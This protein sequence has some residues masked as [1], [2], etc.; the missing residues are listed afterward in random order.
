MSEN[1]VTAV[2]PNYETF[3]PK[4]AVVQLSVSG[5][6]LTTTWVPFSFFMNTRAIKSLAFGLGVLK[7]Q[8]I[9]EPVEFVIQARN[10]NG[11]NRKSGRDGFFVS[12]VT[13]TK[14]EVPCEITD[15]ENGQYFV[16][17]MVEQECDVTIYV[18]FLDDKGKT[19]PIRGSPYSA[20][21]VEGV[22]HEMNHMFGPSLPKSTSKAI[23]HISSWMKETSTAANIK[24]KNLEDI[25][26]LI[27]VVD[28]VK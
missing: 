14:Q 10:D 1:E 28:A 12:I 5:N 13:S 19:V 16:K 26:V 20:S 7:E 23:E 9:G 27:S 11:E 4:D 3:G 22:K 17:Y 2:T 15:M 6:D 8:A 25:K 21:F 18:T 24:D